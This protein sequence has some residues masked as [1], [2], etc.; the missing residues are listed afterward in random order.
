M[1]NG[2]HNGQARLTNEQA[3]EICNSLLG[4]KRLAAIYGV[5]KATI[6][7]IRNG[8]SWTHATGQARRSRQPM[9]VPEGS[10]IT[11]EVLRM[12]VNYDPLTGV[13]TKRDTGRKMGFAKEDGYLRLNLGRRKYAAHRLAWL[14]MT[15]SFPEKL[16][17]HRNGIVDDNRFENL[18][19]AS[20]Q[21]N[22][23]NAKGFGRRG[24]PKGVR[25]RD[26]SFSMHINNRGRLYAAYGFRTADLASEFYE[27]VAEMMHGEFAYHLR[28]GS[29]NVR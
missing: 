19:E 9:A 23:V 1:A 7:R 18:R 4:A 20:Y 29:S 11:A 28:N 17:D 16:I 22:V 15:G 2:V 8:T 14:Y 27:L 24:L 3:V 25:F 26:G 10:E 13:F 5:H 21:Q 12:L 6:Q